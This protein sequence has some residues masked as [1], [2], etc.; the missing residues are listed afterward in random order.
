MVKKLEAANIVVLQFLLQFCKDNQQQ[1]VVLLPLTVKKL[2]KKWN[3]IDHTEFAGW[4]KN[5]VIK[6]RLNDLQSALGLSQLNRL[7]NILERR[8]KIAE[9][10]DNCLADLGI[11]LPYQDPRNFSSY[12]L[13]PIRYQTQRRSLSKRNV[14]LFKR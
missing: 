3:H 5:K 12:H 8:H 4:I 11:Q 14:L 1:K 13:Y 6:F 10:Y 2:Q 7:E 9:I